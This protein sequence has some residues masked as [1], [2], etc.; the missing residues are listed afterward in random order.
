MS[1]STT[2][3]FLWSDSWLLA[4]I[5]GASSGG[6]RPTLA[7]IIAVGDSLNHAIFTTSEINGGV[8]RLSRAGLVQIEGEAFILTAAGTEITRE[9]QK[10]TQGPHKHMETIRARLGAPDWTPAQKPD[11]AGN[12]DDPQIYAS[13]SEIAKAYQE[14]LSLLKTPKKKKANKA[15]GSMATRVTPPT[16]QEPRHG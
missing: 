5:Q 8:S 6:E 11:Q 2:S 1:A 3:R 9:Q 13:E 15:V 14:Y 7:R 10:K 12:S 4:A 16:E